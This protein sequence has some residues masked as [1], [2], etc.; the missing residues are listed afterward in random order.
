MG[1]ASL[2]WYPEGVSAERPPGSIHQMGEA[3]ALT[4]ER[5]RGYLE[6]TVPSRPGGIVAPPHTYRL[7]NLDLRILSD[8]AFYQD[9]GA[10]FGVVPRV[11]WERVARPELD[12]QYRMPLGLNCVLVRSHDRLV[13]IETGVGDKE[14]HRRQASPAADGTLL[15]ELAAIGVRAGEVDVV[16]NTHLHADHCGWN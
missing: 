14:G 5:L 1:G 4:H 15:A 3:R 16:I 13:L 6:A 11:M 7:G 10:V 12:G 9:A 8:G 2:A